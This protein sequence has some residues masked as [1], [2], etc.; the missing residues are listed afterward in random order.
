MKNL[1]L[2]PRDWIYILIFSAIALFFLYLT[3]LIDKE[4]YPLGKGILRQFA[5]IVGI[6]GIMSII[7]SRQNANQVIEMAVENTGVGKEAFFNGLKHISPSFKSVDYREKLKN[8]NQEI[9]IFVIYASSWLKENL[10]VIIEAVRNKNVKLRLCFLDPNSTSAKA[11]NEK[12]EEGDLISR[13]KDSLEF[14]KNTLSREKMIKNNIKVY[15]QKHVPQHCIYRMDDKIYV[16][17]YVL[18]PGRRDTPVF[19]FEKKEMKTGLYSYYLGDLEGLL[20][21]K[22]AWEI[23]IYE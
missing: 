17:N 16:I 2:T 3:E 10:G 15:L 20:C 13:I 1:R 11:L 22:S 12:F 21:S 7:L 8:T 6:S 18:N 14:V 4:Q 23:D 9:D 5:T 19:C